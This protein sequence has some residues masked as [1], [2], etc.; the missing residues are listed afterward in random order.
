MP[1][2]NKAG[3]FFNTV[4]LTID[5]AGVQFRDNQ[6]ASWRNWQTRWIQN[7]VPQRRVGSSPTEA[8]N[9]IMDGGPVPLATSPS[10]PL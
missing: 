4:H 3:L 6:T 5:S 9:I 8:I 1:G 2:T 7:P 10:H